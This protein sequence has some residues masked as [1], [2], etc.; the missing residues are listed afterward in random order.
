VAVSAGV[1]LAT[2]TF[3]DGSAGVDGPVFASVPAVSSSKADGVD[4][5]IVGASGGVLTGGFSVLSGTKTAR[6]LGTVATLADSAT[7]AG[8]GAIALAMSLSSC[9][10]TAKVPPSLKAKPPSGV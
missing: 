4:V 6:G 7:T 9:C 5:E 2:A 3:N 1:V 10:K 8:G